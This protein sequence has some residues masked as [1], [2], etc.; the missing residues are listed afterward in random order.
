MPVKVKLLS[1]EIVKK[2][3][4]KTPIYLRSAFAGDALPLFLSSFIILPFGIWISSMYWI[5]WGL[6]A[7]GFGYMLVMI[8][9]K[10][11]ELVIQITEKEAYA[12]DPQLIETV[13]AYCK[14]HNIE[15]KEDVE[16]TP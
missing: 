8:H 12:A 14:E 13:T 1:G 2:S 5:E 11:N 9:Y 16:C 4:L 10:L 3:Q 6:V 15:Y 7:V